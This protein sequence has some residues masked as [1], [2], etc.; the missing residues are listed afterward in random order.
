M[1]CQ[2]LHKIRKKQTRRNEIFTIHQHEL[3]LR[4]SHGPYLKTF[5]KIF[6]EVTIKLINV[7]IK[8]LYLGLI[9]REFIDLLFSR[10]H[11]Q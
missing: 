10:S 9:W 5:Y 1:T 6:N 3:E 11:D 4:H 2:M 7:R 8:K